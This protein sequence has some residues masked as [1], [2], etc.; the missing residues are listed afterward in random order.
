MSAIAISGLSNILRLEILNLF[1]ILF[2]A[3]ADEI[4]FFVF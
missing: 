3:E 4:L 1:E 2:F